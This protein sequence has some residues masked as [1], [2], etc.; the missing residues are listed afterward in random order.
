[1]KVGDVAGGLGL[2]FG[3]TINRLINRGKQFKICFIIS[4]NL[5]VLEKLQKIHQYCSS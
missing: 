2:E 4:E 5:I 3:F 1:M